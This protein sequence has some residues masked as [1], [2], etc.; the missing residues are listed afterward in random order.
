MVLLLASQHTHSISKAF[1]SFNLNCKFQSYTTSSSGRDRELALLPIPLFTPL[2]L[3]LSDTCS[4]LLTARYLMSSSSRFR[5]ISPTLELLPFSPYKSPFVIQTFL[6]LFVLGIS[7]FL[8]AA[9]INLIPWRLGRY[10]V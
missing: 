3:F 8:L 6:M 4:R 7:G 10:K 9:T 5:V 2:L 1:F